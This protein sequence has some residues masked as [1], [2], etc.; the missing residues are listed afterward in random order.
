VVAGCRQLLVG[1][2]VD[3]RLL[4]ALGGPGA[5]KFL[6]GGQHDDTY[7]L[8]VWAARGLL[9]AW[10]DEALPE[11]LAATCDVAG[12]V[13]EMAAKVVARHAVGEALDAV[14]ALRDDPVPRVRRAAERAVVRLTASGA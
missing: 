10:R 1:R 13:R 6:D 2:P 8:R 14:V 5:A 7:W 9:W 4:L 3:P 11:L 12:R